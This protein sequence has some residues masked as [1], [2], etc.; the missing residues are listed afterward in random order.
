MPL[1]IPYF[2]LIED[3]DASYKY[4]VTESDYNIYENEG[5]KWITFYCAAEIEIIP[6]ENGNPLPWVEINIPY[7]P[8]EFPVIDVDTILTGEAYDSERDDNLTNIYFFVHEGFEKPNIQILEKNG[9]SL[10][11]KITENSDDPRSIT[12]FAEFTF[13]PE[14][15]K[16]FT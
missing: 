14:R 11:A 7:E 9:S 5:R 12:V 2:I 6:N 16:S 3:E 1:D 4:K 15:S 10:I 8:N 13:N